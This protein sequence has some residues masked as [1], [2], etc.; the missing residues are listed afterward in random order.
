MA[1]KLPHR[2]SISIKDPETMFRDFKDRTVE[3]PLAQQADTL[4]SYMKHVDERDIALELP[5]GSGKTL[6]GLLI[7][8]W[9]RRS[10][11]ERCIMLC[12]TKQLVHQVVEQAKEKYGIQ[13]LNFSG[14]KRNFSN[15]SK[16]AFSNCEAIGVATYSALFNVNPFFDDVHTIIFDDAHTAESY[17]S[18]MWSLKVRRSADEEFFNCVWDIIAPYTPE[19]DQFR[20]NQED[21]RELDQTH[22]NKVPTPYLL[23]CKNQLTAAINQICASDSGSEDYGYVWSKIKNHLHACHLY[24]TAQ[25]ILIRPLIPP[26]K[27]FAPFQNAKQRIYMSATLGEG[28]E[29]ER[30]FGRRK[31]VRIPAPDGW[32]KQGVGRRFFVFPMRKY[33]EIESLVLAANWAK[34]FARTLILTRSNKDADFAKQA[35]DANDTI[36]HYS[37]FDATQLEQSK[38]IFTQKESAFAILANRYDGIDLIGDEC[39]YLIIYGLPEATNLQ[40]RFISTRMGASLLF[41]VRLRTRVTQAVGRCTR[42]ATDYALVVIVGEKIHQYFHK[43]EKRELLH[44]ELQSEANFGVE[45]SKDKDYLELENDI[46]IFIEQGEEWKEAN[47]HII[48]DRDQLTQSPTPFADQLG[49]S[50]VYEVDFQDSLWDSDFDNALSS[51]KKVLAKISG[52]IELKGYSAL[53][54]YLAGS[55]AYQADE[56]KVAKS[57]F[58]DAFSCSK[59]LPWLKQVQEFI[60]K[61]SKGLSD[62]L[63][64][65]DRIELIEEIFERFGKSSSRKIDEYI[66]SIRTGLSSLDAKPFEEAQVRLGSLLGFRSYNS[67]DSGAPD[68]W[69]VSGQS[70]I[71]FEDYTATKDNPV[72]SKG[73]VLQAKG[74]PDTLLEQF[75]GID[76]SVVFCST[77]EKLDEAAIPHTDDI[78]Y[79]NATDFNTF[80]EESI[81]IMRDLWNSFSSS[82]DIEWRESAAQK[83][84]EESLST[85][86]I[87]AMLTSKKLSSL[88]KRKKG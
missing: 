81:N 15:S 62:D 63:I 53:W 51:A 59:T 38:K 45:Q 23:K 30:T 74:H 2:S 22:V 58:A 10:K 24:Y 1:F 73:K 25:S 79:I 87:L 78:C 27:S 35:I 84:A 21:E 61:E 46:D 42:S 70:G 76:F 18:D 39:R 29:L 71:V 36:N 68:P 60:S 11:N 67:E 34:K 64:E 5:T 57:H 47:S 16:A 72:I 9:R 77:S 48:G 13:A 40:E 83:L 82:G 33:P 44:P 52:G 54:N 4:R 28:G 26:T 43:P 66:Q 8:E 12:P 69:W 56:K 75:S 17:V 19:N 20:F 88:A 50:V 14:P 6:V 55:A 65:G 80:A 37:I 31:I 85:N 41:D 86:N 49:N 7:A 3:G 32:D